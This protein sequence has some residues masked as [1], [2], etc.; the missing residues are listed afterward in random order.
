MPYCIISESPAVS[1]FAFIYSFH[2]NYF[3][4]LAHKE[5]CAYLDILVE[6]CIFNE[7]YM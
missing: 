4:L 6:H 7:V 1:F 3:Q 2:K 5:N